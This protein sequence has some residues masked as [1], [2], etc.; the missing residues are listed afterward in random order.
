VFYSEI[1]LKRFK[2]FL[3]VQQRVGPCQ[4]VG[5]PVDGNGVIGCRAVVKNI[6]IKS[7][8]GIGVDIIMDLPVILERI[9]DPA[10]IKI[11]TGRFEGILASFFRGSQG[12]IIFQVETGFFDAVSGIGQV[13]GNDDPV[14]FD[15]LC[16][17]AVAG[18]S[19]VFLVFDTVHGHVGDEGVSVIGREVLRSQDEI[20]DVGL[21]TLVGSGGR[22]RT[23]VKSQVEAFVNISA[24][25]GIE[26]KFFIGSLNIMDVGI[27]FE[28]F[29]IFD[30]IVLVEPVI[31]GV[32]SE[33]EAC[34]RGYGLRN[35][36]LRS[37][38]GV[39]EGSAERGV[40][41]NGI[42]GDRMKNRSIGHIDI[43]ASEA[44]EVVMEEEDAGGV[45]SCFQGIG[46]QRPGGQGGGDADEEGDED[47]ED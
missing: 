2:F 14:G 37:G 17:E 44:I 42:I 22:K 34:F 11:F 29:I 40:E 15:I 39:T 33:V 5:D 36:A 27:S 6:G 32:Y 20:N 10:E 13:N 7:A 38:S 19:P 41:D 26:E 1:Q 47:R 24:E 46:R 23:E 28:H 18:N 16:E 12:K 3:P 31:E 30:A 35:Q 45:E 21:L 8:E 25:S 9:D 43:K 4:F